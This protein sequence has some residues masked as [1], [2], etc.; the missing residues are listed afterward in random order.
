MRR[1]PG[2]PV[3]DRADETANEVV[4]TTLDRESGGDEVAI[5]TGLSAA[6]VPR[7]GAPQTRPLVVTAHRGSVLLGGIRGLS[8]WRWLYI[9]QF[10]I[11]TP[12][13]GR[14]LGTRLVRACVQEAQRRGCIGLYVDTFDPDVVTFYRRMGF[15]VVGKIADF[16]PGHTRVFMARRCDAP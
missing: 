12:H 10:W 6:I 16:P 3:P 5:E 9:R 1:K 4:I 13:R 11:D 14:G 7:F 8:H 2:E 15:A